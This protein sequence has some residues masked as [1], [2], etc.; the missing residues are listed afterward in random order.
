MPKQIASILLLAAFTL[1]TF[2]GIFVLAD[3]YAN[4][5]AYAKNC[6]N[7]A[8]PKLNCNGKC[9]MMKKMREE[10]KKEQENTERKCGNKNEIVSFKS[11]FPTVENP[12]TIITI[13]QKISPKSMGSSKDR[14]LDIFHPPQA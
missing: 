3:Y 8:R 13:N 4:T 9:F 6:V 14:S 10:E 2:T 11:F 12:T 5:S 1:Q 7:K